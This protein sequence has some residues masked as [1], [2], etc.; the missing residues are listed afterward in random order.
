MGQKKECEEALAEAMPIYHKALG[1]LKTLKKE[2]IDEVKNYKIVAPEVEKVFQ[3]V[4]LLYGRKQNFDEAKKMMSNPNQFL[5]DLQTY[6]ADNMS[7]KMHKAL[8][9]FSRD[10]GLTPE[11]LESK[12]KACKSICLFIRA[13]DNYVE[14]MKV[15]KPK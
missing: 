3:A 1:A 10:P 8:Q 12:S 14:V 13:M 5:T 6:K 7:E 9:K 4:C 15:I 2:D 11:I